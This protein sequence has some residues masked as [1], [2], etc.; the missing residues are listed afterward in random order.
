MD[1]LSD[2]FALGP[3]AWIV[4]GLVLVALEIVVPGA[5]MLW[6]GL[7]ALATGALTFVVAMPWAGQIVVFAVLA[8]VAAYEAR[9]RFA[10]DEESDDPTLNTGAQR[11]VGT[12]YTLE[13]PIIGG[14][15]RLRIGDGSWAV[16]GPDLPAGAT[17]E[18]VAVEGTRLRVAPV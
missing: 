12:R 6:F 17:V 13:E 2:L 5:F 16:D 18:V 9:R 15:G 10:G 1:A 14:R 4:L 8:A 11:L 3:W 7:A